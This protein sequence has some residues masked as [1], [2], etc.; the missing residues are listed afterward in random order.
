MCQIHILVNTY[1]NHTHSTPLSETGLK[2]YIS[3]SDLYLCKQ[4]YTQSVNQ[5]NR[6]P[7]TSAVNLFCVQSFVESDPTDFFSFLFSHCLIQQHYKY[8]TCLPVIPFLCEC[9]TKFM[10]VVKISLQLLCRFLQ[11]ARISAAR[12]KMLWSGTGEFITET[13]ITFAL[14]PTHHPYP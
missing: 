10:K 1:H 13:E 4:H 6:W 5:S 7:L 11:T 9:S 3:Q 14:Q 2:N 12:L 8:P